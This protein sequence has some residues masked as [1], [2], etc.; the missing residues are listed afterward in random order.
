LRKEGVMKKLTL[1]SKHFIHDEK[2]STIV[3]VALVFTALIII[4]ALVIDIGIAYNKTAEIE[5]AADAAALAAGKLL[6]VDTEDAVKVSAIKN[7]AIEYA[8]KNGITTLQS[9]DIELLNIVDGFYTQLQINIPLHMETSF[10]KIIGVDFLD[11]TRSAKVKITPCKKVDDAVPLSIEKTKM[12]T[13]LAN[14][15]TTHLA[16]KYGAGE[17]TTGF[18]G[19]IDLDGVKGGGAN[20]YELWLAFGY[21]SMLSAGEQ[22]Y[23]VE[24]GNM[25][26]PTNDALTIRYNGCTHFPDSGGCTIDHYSTNCTRVVK[27]PVI[28]YDGSKNARICGFAAFV[29]EPFTSSGY[30]YGSFIKLVV[31]GEESDTV[32]VGDALDYGMYNVRLT[33]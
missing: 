1:S 4:A 6:P 29:L 30:I 20:D 16:L 33:D 3:I 26:G 2:G 31:S 8:V 23:P 22:L 32:Q 28:E 5:N 21:T 24:A 27:T 7:K 11:V 17:G 19:A 18:F 14:G 9:N 15:Q 12:D 13:Y 25:A 10:A